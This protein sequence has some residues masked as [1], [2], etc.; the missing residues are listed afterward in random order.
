MEV[1]FQDGLDVSQ[2]VQHIAVL[3]SPVRLLR[4]MLRQRLREVVL[5]SGEALKSAAFDL[6]DDHV[7]WS[8][9]GGWPAPDR[10]SSQALFWLST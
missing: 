4:Q 1:L 2:E 6:M 7:F 10:T 8:I 5:P 9:L 3:E